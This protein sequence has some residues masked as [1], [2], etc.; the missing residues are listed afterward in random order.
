MTTE[1]PDPVDPNLPVSDASVTSKAAAAV[2][3][4]PRGLLARLQQVSPTFRDFKPVALRIDKAVGARFPEAD[5]KVI[6]AAMRIH[7]ASTRYLK[8]L[9]KSTHR[10]DLDGVEAGE[11]SEE[12]KTH[13]RETLKQRFAEATRKKR[14]RE[15]EEADKRRAEEAEQRR[16]EKLQQLVG[17]FSKS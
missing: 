2:E 10:Y 7:T 4:D 5:R 15:R 12:H 13:A 16:N 8:A 14:E 3:L 17:R 6:R 9:E 1:T 11:L